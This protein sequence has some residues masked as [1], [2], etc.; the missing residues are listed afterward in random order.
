MN[1]K[2]SFWIVGAVIVLVLIVIFATKS[3]KTDEYVV[4]IGYAPNI[5]F[6]PLHIADKQGF[7]AKEG[8]KVQLVPLQSAQQ[9][10]EALVRKEL[11][12]VPFLS[13]V[14]VMTGEAV[15]PGNV[16]LVSVS[17]VSLE[18]QFD[19]L[20]VKKDSKIASLAD[21]KGKKIGVFPGTTGMNFLK[22][23]FKTKSV[24]YTGTEF[25]QLPPPNQLQA[26]ESGAIDA[27]F[28]Y[29]PNY[30]IGVEKFGFKKVVPE[31][32]FASQINHAAFGGYWFSTSFAAE[33]PS[34]ADKVVKAMDEGNDVLT[35][36]PTL[37]RSVA[38]TIY[39]LDDAV[40]QK[41]N[42][43]KMVST[44]DFKPE[45]FTSFIDFL[46]TIGE[47][48]VKPDLSNVFYK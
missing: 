22:E 44:K 18:N 42:L 11:D 23:Y 28:S 29:E 38:K 43:V 26:L 24:D 3:Q 35:S 41:I 33:H 7:F 37:A 4:K 36:D 45:M 17:D 30:T 2:K 13:T 47:L 25:V 15:S 16:K 40:A 21:L 12:Y 6:L 20:M 32:I 9:L 8:V 46:V 48:K 5:G 31:S 10:Y 1:M 19:A 27:L 14:V 34:L 39:I